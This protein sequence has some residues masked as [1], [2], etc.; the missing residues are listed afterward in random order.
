VSVDLEQLTSQLVHDYKRTVRYGGKGRASFRDPEGILSGEVD[1]RYDEMGRADVDMLVQDAEGADTDGLGLLAFFY[2][3][4]PRVVNG[5]LQK[6]LGTP[7]P[8]SSF[9][10]GVEGGTVSAES[11]FC[12]Q[13]FSWNVKTGQR[14]TIR[15]FPQ[16]LH[17]MASDRGT[18]SYWVMPLI[19]FTPFDK[20]PFSI[21]F[22]M[23][24]T[25][26]LIAGLSDYGE[27][28]A[29][30]NSG[31]ETRKVTALMMG[32]VGDRRTDRESLYQWLPADHVLLLSLVSGTKI[33]SPWAELW[34]G[35]GKLVCRLH[36]VIGDPHYTKGHRA[37]GTLNS[38]HGLFL[39]RARRSENYGKPFIRA[40]IKHTTHG[41]SHA[42]NLEPRT[43]SLFQALDG[44]CVE[45][46]LYKDPRLEQILTREQ[47][48]AVEDV[49]RKANET[50]L[51]IATEAVE[52]D[53][54]NVV[55][56]IAGNVARAPHL[57]RGFGDAVVALL[58]RFG[59][60]DAEI[61]CSYRAARPQSDNR[62]WPEELAR[63]RGTILH[64]G[65]MPLGDDKEATLK[66]VRLGNHLHDILLRII[67][68]L[69]GYDGTYQPSV[70][71]WATIQPVDWVKP[72]TPPR[73]LGY[74]DAA[75][76]G[77]AE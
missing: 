7:N 30:L 59:L 73:L 57:S 41:G 71:R 8:C 44:F 40:A 37:F 24:D 52:A 62:E 43:A 35:D 5:K 67:F 6:P 15:F 64:K 18:P 69:L 70:A 32:E 49:V 56:R 34:D 21:E 29:K 53:Q 12:N 20:G 61:M 51:R 48:V 65:F 75:R 14:V 58:D 68:R 11:V 19:N 77:D 27:T 23:D 60:P 36:R 39:S 45:F 38:G 13:N 3:D 46:G 42:G 17:F 74:D 72:D 33:G 16:W 63:C 31:E 9:E 2:S 22:E 1:I 28:L 26:G 4:K 54:Q 50:L 10:A 76:A 25:K 66:L 47:R 55:T